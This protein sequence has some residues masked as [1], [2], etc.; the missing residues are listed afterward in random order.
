MNH[1][2]GDVMSNKQANNFAGYLR[3]LDKDKLIYIYLNNNVC[4]STEPK[5][6]QFF[7]DYF[8]YDG[9][10]AHG[11]MYFPDQEKIYPK[12]YERFNQDCVPKL[13]VVPYSA[14]SLITG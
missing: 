7:E 8:I 1:K 14:I 3:S 11:T 13:N 9:E 6:L 5:H 12:G 2:D 10:S 4:I